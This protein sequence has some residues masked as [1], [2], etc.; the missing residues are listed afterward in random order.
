MPSAYMWPLVLLPV[1]IKTPGQ[2]RTRS[3]GTVTLDS[4]PSG[5]RQHAFDCRGAYPCGT[6][7][8]WHR[9]GRLYAGTECANDI[10]GPA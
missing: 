7:E 3:G 1:I 4:V 2:Y 5:I 6:R 8:Y 9:S 10:M